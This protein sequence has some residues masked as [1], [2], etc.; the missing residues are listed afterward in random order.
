MKILFS[1]IFVIS[2]LSGCSTA[3]ESS[4]TPDDLYYAAGKDE[5]E[6]FVKKNADELEKYQDYISSLDDR[7]LRMKVA[8]RNRWG[9]IDHFNYWNDMRYDH[10]DY[11]YN[12]Y[13]KYWGNPGYS[14]WNM[15]NGFSPWNKLGYGSSFGY[16]YGGN[17]YG[18]NNPVYTV[19]S[20]VNPKASIIT[21]TS[22]TNLSAYKNKT[23]NN[24]NKNI[25]SKNG[26][27]GTPTT[28]G[29]G[30]NSFGN[31]IRKVLST[32]VTSGLEG[33]TSSYE[34]AAR[35]FSAPSSGSSS[36]SSGS[37]SSG[38]SSSAGGS[39]GGFGSTGSS[40]GSG[41]AGRGN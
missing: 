29:S 26:D 39:S 32:A 28:S 17:Y 4:Q 33:N 3:Y 34:R 41:R 23:Y 21:S 7:Y 36:S 9:S 16:G 14:A 5:D 25:F 1:S 31:L 8:N 19:I 12:T 27:Y 40:A 35:T 2:L 13:N 20:Y 11:G 30:N 6:Q 10:Y 15:Y 24:Y 18:W 38:T 22:G 37:S